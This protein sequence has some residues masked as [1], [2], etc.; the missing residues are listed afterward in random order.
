MNR[1]TLIRVAALLAAAIV[2]VVVTLTVRGSAA[3]AAPAS[4]P[5][6]TA[7][8][9]RTDLSSTVLTPGTLDY[10]PSEPIVNRIAGTYTWLQAPSATVTSGEV[11]YN[12]DNEP[13]VLM[14]GTL[15]AWR[16]FDP[17]MTD[18][19]DI[20]QL[21][22]GLL[23]AGDAQGLFT[24]P[25]DHFSTQTETAVRRWQTAVGLPVTGQIA[26]GTIVFLPGPIRVDAQRVLSGQMAGPGDQPYVVSTTTRVVTVP[27][28]ANLPTVTP[29]QAVS[30][31]LPDGS[32]TPGKTSAIVAVPSQAGQS[33][34]SGGSSGSGSSTSSTS[35]TPTELVVTPDNPAVTGT[36]AGVPVQVSLTVQ[37]VRNVLAVPV[38]ALLALTDG[39]YGL[40]IVTH[41]GAHELV[42]VHTGVFAGGRVQIT[43]VGIQ[44]GARVVVAQ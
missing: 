34:Q 8:V 40:E 3:P 10:A 19:P 14:S 11:L 26:L 1:L 30:I 7:L 18:G 35:S 28:N 33:G 17:G 27:L 44:P 9:V 23:A 21:E 41:S 2:G 38:P 6:T 4:L 43:G 22:A 31:V 12:V 16:G 37:S 15:P 36:S 20:G 39:G 24:E 32:N 29:G 13:V 25:S 42:G 5:S